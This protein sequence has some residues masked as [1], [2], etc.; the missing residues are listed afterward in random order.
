VGVAVAQHCIL[1]IEDQ[2]DLAA[3]YEAILERAGYR[4]HKTHSGEEGLA[5]FKAVGADLILL[6]MTLP[7][8][9]GVQVLREL[10]EADA[11]IPIIILT[12][13]DEDQTREQCESLGVQG[14]IRK[15]PDFDR[16]ISKIEDA[17]K[18]PA[19]EAE[20]V[21]LRLPARVAAHLRA[22]DSNLERAITML[23]EREI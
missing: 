15:P 21:T 16:L 14:Y 19:E 11:N 1:V 22:I 9:R 7:E 20:V 4:V 18:A 23:V 13:L 2:E 10:R 3:V 12:G 6:D 8:M 17:L 5:E